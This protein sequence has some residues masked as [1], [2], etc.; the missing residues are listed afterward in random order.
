M[1]PCMGTLTVSTRID[2]ETAEKLE[3]LSKATKRSRSFLAAEAIQKYVD[4]QSWQ[5]DAIEKGI[6]EA[7]KG[8]FATDKEMKE[9]FARWK[10]NE[11]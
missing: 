7:D 9:F 8:N 5:I 1:E 11:G 10:V 3:E 4:E 6:E 2:N